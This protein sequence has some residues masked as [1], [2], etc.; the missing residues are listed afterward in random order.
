MAGKQKLV[1]CLCVRNCERYLPYII[2]NLN[3]LR[4]L[5]YHLYVVFAVDNCVDRSEAFLDYYRSQWHDVT[6]LKIDNQSPLRT[7]RIAAARNACLEV[8]E[9]IRPAYHCMIDADEVN[10]PP[11]NMELIHSLLQ[12]DGWDVVSFN[13]PEFYDTWALVDGPYKHHCWGWGKYNTQVIEHYRKKILEKIKHSQTKLIPCTSAFNGFAFY[14][15]EL[16]RSLR[17]DGTYEKYLTLFSDQERLDT[18]EL[19]ALE[20]NAPDIELSPP[21]DEGQCCEHVYYHVCAIRECGARIF[22]C[23]YPLFQLKRSNGTT[24]SRSN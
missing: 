22:I 6:V 21:H 23:R 16:V 24:I 19:L 13:R 17:Y 5:P 8:V 15:S 11:W 3:R 14:R 9:S 12:Y 1:C 10:V 4:A 2:R 18:K 7:V 20:L